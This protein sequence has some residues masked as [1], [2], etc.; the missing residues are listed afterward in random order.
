MVHHWISLRNDKIV[1]T[2]ENKKICRIFNKN[3]NYTNFYG[4]YD[5]EIFLGTFN[6]YDS[7]ETFYHKVL[8]NSSGYLR[9]YNKN[10][11]SSMEHNISY[12][13]NRIGSVPESN[14]RKIFPKKEKYE[15]VKTYK[16]RE[17][18]NFYIYAIQTTKFYYLICFA[19]S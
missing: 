5:L 12:V 11:T 16:L 1:N 6:D 8:S 18:G 17:D 19:T 9:N 10:I 3:K 15:T 13:L 7:L 14:Y 2:C 4:D